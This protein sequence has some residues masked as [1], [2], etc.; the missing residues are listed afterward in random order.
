M[1][2]E[3]A[4]SVKYG[5]RLAK[6][7]SYG[8]DRSVSPPQPVTM[9]KPPESYLPTAPMVYAVV[10]EPSIVDNPDIRSY[11]PHVHGRCEPPALI[12]LQMN[13]IAVEID[14]YIDTAFITVTGSW[15]VHCV[16]ASKSCDCRIAIPM[17]EQGSILGVDITATRASYCTQL[18]TIE[19][20]ASMGNEGK[21]QDG[22][23]LKQDLYTLD[24][25]QVDGGSRLSAKLSWL[26]K[27]LYHDGQFCLNVPFSFPTYVTPGGKKLSKRERIQLN[28]NS[29]TGSGI[30][31][32]YASHPLKELRCEVG[33]LGFLYEAEVLTWSSADIEFSYTVSSN[34]IIGGFLLQSPALHDFDQRDMFCFYLFPGTTQ[35]KKEFRKK[36]VFIVDISGSMHG[37]PLEKAKDELLTYLSKLDPQDSF[38]IIAFNGE[39]YLFSSSVVLATKEA[40]ERAVQWIK[41]SLIAAG[42][43]N[44]LLPLNQAMEMLSETTNCF[45]LIFLI[46]DGAV[47]NE[48]HICNVIKGYTR[49]RGSKCPRIS[50]FGIGSYCNHYFL[51]MMA[52]IGRGHYE[53]AHDAA[54]IDYRMRR[55]FTTASSVILANIAIK[56]LAHLGELELYPY[57][58]P[59]LSSGSPLILLGRYKGNFPKSLSATGVLADLG[60]F[61]VNLKIQNAKDIPLERVFAKRQIDLLTSQAWLSGSKQL[62]GKVARISLQSGVPSEY[63]RMILLQTDKTKNQKEVDLKGPEIILF[64]GLAIGF[65]NLKATDE[66]LA[67]GIKA[68][69][70]TDSTTDILAKSASK[71]CGRLLDCCCCMC[72]IQAC[73]KLNDQSAVA[74]TQLCTA[75]ACFQCIDCI[76]DVCVSCDYC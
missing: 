35:S 62:E 49:D 21:T 63:T 1:A 41:S 71:Y 52:Q 76:F 15:R 67:P 43:T 4:D 23:F 46:T 48:K 19:D 3:F 74:F 12:P 69:K 22:G 53:F 44:I 72:F 24:I 16:M 33:K 29:S 5:L 14:C 11:Q 73:S 2:D 32:K 64:R 39:T 50:I 56:S 6:R 17:G 28:V 60:S 57:Q 20:T 61:E 27:L 65:G 13:D 10:S 9:M 25:P 30:V 38:S 68:I 40:V 42:S 18:I 54:S 58:I 59:D 47:E 45:P 37:Q 7:I 8:K 55:L 34:E 26:Q 31:C 70:S 66:N 51:R 36:V 75:L